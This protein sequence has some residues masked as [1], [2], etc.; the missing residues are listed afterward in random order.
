MRVSLR[1]FWELEKF[2]MQLQDTLKHLESTSETLN[3][4]MQKTLDEAKQTQLDL[5]SEIKL[6]TQQVQHCKMVVKNKNKR[7]NELSNY[8]I[9]TIIIMMIFTWV[10]YYK[11][12]FST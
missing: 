9:A 7:L 6:L 4:A 2:V 12:C 10:M 11:I 8:K 3:K 5:E 1:K